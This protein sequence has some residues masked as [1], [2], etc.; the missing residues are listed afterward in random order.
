MVQDM[1]NQM[2]LFASD[3]PPARKPQTK[4]T[5]GKYKNEPFE[6]L[7][8]DPKYAMYLMSSRMVLPSSSIAP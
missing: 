4:L 1:T 3:G 8:Q 2:D 6:V 7:E 5:F